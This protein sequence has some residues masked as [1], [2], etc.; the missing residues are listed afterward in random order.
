MRRPSLPGLD[1]GGV[2]T[3]PQRTEIEPFE[4]A[5]ILEVSEHEVRELFRVGVPVRAARDLL[6]GGSLGRAGWDV[7]RPTCS[8]S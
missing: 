1:V 2:W 5:Y 3:L 7:K 6:A 4:L 8:V